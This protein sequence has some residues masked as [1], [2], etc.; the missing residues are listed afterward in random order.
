MRHTCGIYHKTISLKFRHIVCEKPQCIP[1]DKTCSH[2]PSS[3]QILPYMLS[4]QSLREGHL[5]TD[6]RLRD[7]SADGPYF[8][9]TYKEFF[10]DELPFIT[11]DKIRRYGK[12]WQ[13]L[14]AGWGTLAV[15]ISSFCPVLRE[16]EPVNVCWPFLDSSENMAHRVL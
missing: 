12:Y 14:P 8:S 15:L 1:G 16:Y 9:I 10:I 6:S 3:C 5:D 2:S 11:L 7:R 13:F 4:S